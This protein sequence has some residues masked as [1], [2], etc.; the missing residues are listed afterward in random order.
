MSPTIILLA[1]LIIISLIFSI[2]AAAKNILVYVAIAMILT[3]LTL[4]VN[5]LLNAAK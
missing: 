3:D 2:L 4:L 1:G 5:L